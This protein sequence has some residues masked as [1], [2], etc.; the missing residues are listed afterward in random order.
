MKAVAT[1]PHA[2]GLEGGAE[3][4]FGLTSGF[5]DAIFGTRIPESDRRRVF[6]PRRS[7]TRGA[8]AA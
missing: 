7:R 5:W 2:A 1:R 3:L 4:A 6:A 8:V